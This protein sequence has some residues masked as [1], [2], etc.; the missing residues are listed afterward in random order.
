MWAW[1]AIDNVFFKR[2]SRLRSLGLGPIRA[3][4]TDDTFIIDR[5]TPLA[6]PNIEDLS[7]RG[8]Q[9]CKSLGFDGGP[10]YGRATPCSSTGR[11]FSATALDSGSLL[12]KTRRYHA[13]GQQVK[14]NL[15]K[16]DKVLPSLGL[17]LPRS[18][19]ESEDLQLEF[20]VAGKYFP[21][22]IV[23]GRSC[24]AAGNH[25]QVNIAT[26]KH[27][28]LLS[29]ILI[30]EKDYQGRHSKARQDNSKNERGAARL[31]RLPVV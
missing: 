29:H 20:I 24:D 15:N 4:D 26:S 27:A 30:S 5:Q 10:F 25:T 22:A 12:I 6:R 3:M 9:R 31:G 18:S 2:G 1:A 21:A 11:I 8:W 13:S 23:L 7:L 14:T 16:E 28:V 19:S 17:K